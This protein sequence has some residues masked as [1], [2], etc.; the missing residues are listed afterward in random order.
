MLHVNLE[1]HRKKKEKKNPQFIKLDS[2]VMAFGFGWRW[3]CYYFKLDVSISDWPQY[4]Y[5]YSTFFIELINNEAT[6]FFTVRTHYSKE[7]RQNN[8]LGG[9]VA[10]FVVSH[11]GSGNQGFD[12]KCLE[13]TIFQISF[14]SDYYSASF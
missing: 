4:H 12:H 13:P 1:I 7:K 9:C 11:F 3:E 8:T 10:F 2:A 14:K 6:N 5:W